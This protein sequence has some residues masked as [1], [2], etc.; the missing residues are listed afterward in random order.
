MNIEE[1]L[2]QARTG[3]AEAG[4][5]AALDAVRVRFLGKKGEL[6]ALLKSLG[7]LDAEEDLHQ[8]ALARA[9]PGHERGLLALIEAEVQVLEDEP[10]AEPLRQPFYRKHVSACHG[11][12][13]EAERR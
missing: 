3:I 9:V 1:L 8:G 10:F 13:V 2:E 11:A 5:E 7:A 12:K 4:D 6:T